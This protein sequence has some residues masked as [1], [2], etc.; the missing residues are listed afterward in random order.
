M[1]WIRIGD[2]KLKI[3]LSAQDAR[4]YALNIDGSDQAPHT[5]GNSIRGILSDLLAETGFDA[6]E[7]KMYI[8]L[9]PSKDGGCELFIT[10]IS[11]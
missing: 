4:H 1:E 9:Y 11:R 10:K 2:N 3:M 8:Q 6:G 7:D 5:S